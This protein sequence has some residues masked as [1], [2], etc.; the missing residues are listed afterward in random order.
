[1]PIGIGIGQNE[2]HKLSGK[3]QVMELY[4]IEG[5]N[6]LSNPGFSLAQSKLQVIFRILCKMHILRDKNI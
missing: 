5:N 6:I 1:M 3:S 4:R 2:S